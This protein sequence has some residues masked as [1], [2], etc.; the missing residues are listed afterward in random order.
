MEVDR[1]QLDAET[2]KPESVIG[3][4]HRPETK[5]RRLIP[6][7]V[8]IALVVMLAAAVNPLAAAMNTKT[9]SFVRLPLTDLSPD[10]DAFDR[11]GVRARVV[12]RTSRSGSEMTLA[13]LNVTRVNADAG[14]TFGAHVH[15]G[16][17]VEDDGGAAGPHFNITDSRGETKVV[18]A[19]TEIWLDF[20]VTANG[21]GHSVA[22]VDFAIPSGE[23][24]SIV[25]HALPTDPTGGAG[26]R[27]AC[28]N[29]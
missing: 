2:G 1:T 19:E 5:P 11:A 14:T 25:I 7:L 9:V 3:R 15:V 16:P 10:A 23:A 29:I 6:L 8:I 27:L 24:N 4:G 26:A 22:L 17:C 20:T 13:T 28:V 21:R 18:S 12:S